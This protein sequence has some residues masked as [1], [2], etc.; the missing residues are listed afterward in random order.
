MEYRTKLDYSSN[1]QIKQYPA[2]ITSLSGATHFGVPFSALTTGPNLSTT[3]VTYEI[4][5]VVSTFSGNSG[6]TT[7]TWYN[8]G[9]QIAASTLSAITSA[10]SAA[11]QNTGAVYTANTTTIIDGNQVALSYT[12]VSF[13]L[14]PILVLDMGGGVYSGS[15]YTEMLTLLS[16]DT[17]DF[18]GRTIW[19][20]VSGITR[21]DS[22]IVNNDAT[23]SNIGSNTSVGSLYYT[24]NGTLTTNTSDER[25]KTNVNRIENALDKVLKL[26]GVYYNWLDNPE[27]GR[28]IGFIAQEVEKIA[29]ELTFVN[30]NSKNSYMGIHYENVV[31]LL[32]EAIKEIVSG[33]VVTLNQTITT[34]TIAAEDNNIELNYNGSYETAG[35][36]GITVAN[37]LSQGVDAEFV[38]DSN[39]YFT[40]NTGLKTKSLCIPFYQPTSS[41]D[42]TGKE[43]EITTDYTYLYIKTPTKW[44][45]TKL[46][47]F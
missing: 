37:G 41:I 44:V 27:G 38:L 9:M 24:S 13:D 3:G 5:N 22:L 23:F 15:V 47:E 19:V 45:R 10:N 21:T 7:F 20:D 32:V 33:D 17:L 42:S 16:A 18:T 40:I 1:R 25:L 14:T 12:G 6:T 35:G 39:G 46:E 2:T 29:P 31:S 26:E 8:S 36:G 11:T 28:R 4:P 30:P 43:G 34:Q